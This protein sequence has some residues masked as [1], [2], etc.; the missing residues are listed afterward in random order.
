VFQKVTLSIVVFLAVIIQI[1]VLPNFFS[2][3]TIPDLFLVLVI[4]WTIRRGF[5]KV[6][7]WTVLAGFFLDLAYH[8]AVGISVISLALVTFG[9][10]SLAKRFL[11]LQGVSRAFMMIALVVFG[12]I[13][14]D[15]FSGV[16]IKIFDYLKND[17]IGTNLP[18]FLDYKIFIKIIYNIFVLAII[19]WPVEKLENMLN[20]YGQ[21]ASVQSRF[22]QR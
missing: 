13:A 3:G 18:N 14:N 21:R 7:P 22:F 4:L 5:E 17:I 16:L 12:T 6:L 15:L 11:A 9:I 10:N 19:Y 1:A 2:P 20:F 8:W